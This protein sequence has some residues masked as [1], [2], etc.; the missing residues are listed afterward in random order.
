MNLNTIEKFCD[1]ADEIHLIVEDARQ[2]LLSCSNDLSQIPHSDHVA[3]EIL[4]SYSMMLKSIEIILDTTKDNV[5][6][7]ILID[8]KA[9]SDQINLFLTKYKETELGRHDLFGTL[10]CRRLHFTPPFRTNVELKEGINEY[11]NYC[12]EKENELTNYIPDINRIKDQFTFSVETPDNYVIF[13]ETK[14][15]KACLLIYDWK[16]SINSTSEIKTTEKY[17]NA[18]YKMFKNVQ[19]DGEDF[20]ER[21]PIYICI[22][23][24]KPVDHMYIVTTACR[25]LKDF[26]DS[27]FNTFEKRK[28]YASSCKFLTSTRLDSLLGTQGKLE[29][30]YAESQ[31]LKHTLSDRIPELGD[32]TEV[33]FSHWTSEYKNTTW[34]NNYLSTDIEKIID[35]FPKDKITKPEL[36]NYL[37]GNFIYHIKTMSN[38]HIS[39]KFKGYQDACKLHKIT[40]KSSIESLEKYIKSN[41]PKWEN[42]YVEHYDRIRNNTVKKK[43]EQKTI[44][45][46]T[47]AFNGNA[48]EY[49]KKYPDCFTNE[50]GETKTNFPLPWS[51]STVHFEITENVD[52]NNQISN[53]FREAFSSEHRVIYN[54]SYGEPSGRSSN[55]EA[56]YNLASVCFKLSCD[57][58]NEKKIIIEDVIDIKD[59]SIKIDREKQSSKE[60]NKV[61]EILTRNKNEFSLPPKSKHSPAFYRGLSAMKVKMSRKRKEKEKQDLIDKVKSRREY[62]ISDKGNS[63]MDIGSYTHNKKLIKHDNESALGWCD[64][65]MKNLFALLCFDNRESTK[66]SNVYE[67]YTSNPSKMFRESQMIENEMEN[68]KK[69]NKLAK[70]LSVYSYSDDMMQFSKGLMVADRFMGERDFKIL[71]SSNKSMLVIAFK[72]DGINTGKSGVP[73]MSL[74]IVDQELQSSFQQTYTRELV[75]Y[76]KYK[77]FF[78]NIMRPQR[79]NQVRLLS[80]FK[81]PSKL[82][83]CFAQFV[84]QSVEIMNWLVEIPIKKISLLKIKPSIKE[85]IKD[86]L[87]P[88]IILSTVTKLSRM[89]IFD[90][91]RYAGFLPLSDY[92]NIKEYILEK[93]DP[94]ITNV[95]DFYFVHTIKRLLLS[96]EA[97]SLSSK[98]NPLT[99]DHENDMIGG[100]QDLNIICPITNSTLRRLE[101]LYNNVYLSIYMMP[102]SLQTRVHNLTS[103]LDVPADWELK[104]RTK[105]GF[106]VNEEIYPKPEMF[107][108]SGSFSINGPLNVVS[109]SDYYRDVV[110]NIGLT[111]S[112][113]ESRE[114]FIL[115][116]YKINT[117][118]SSKKCSKADIISDK[119]IFEGLNQFYKTNSHATKNYEKSKIKCQGSSFYIMK[120]IVKAYNENPMAVRDFL[121]TYS[122]NAGIYEFIKQCSSGTNH[123]VFSSNP[124]KFVHLNH[125]LTVETYLKL[126]FSH[127]D[128]I[129]EVNDGTNG[130][131]LSQSNVTVLKSK[132]VSE[133]LYDLIKQYNNIS[134]NDIKNI[135]KMD[136]GNDG[137][138][139]TFIQLL[140]FVMSRTKLNCN[141]TDFL[142]SVFEKMQRTKV[143]REIYLMSMKV[144]M[145]LYFIEHTYKHIAQSDPSE[146]ISI[147][148][149]Y[150]IKA[151]AKLSMDTITTY[152][153][154]LEK[155]CDTKLS[156]LSADQSKWSASDLTYKY[157]LAIIMNPVLTTGEA[158]L[159]IECMLLYV[160]AKKVCIPTDIFMNLRQGQEKFGS[161]CNAI[162]ILTNFLQTNTF[163]VSMNWLQG[164]LNYLSSVYHSCAML[165]Y[166]KSMN[167]STLGNFSTKWMVHS[168]DN[169]TS[170]V[171]DGNSEELLKIYNCDNFSEFLFRTIETHFKSFCIT[172]NPKKSYA[173]VSLVEFISERIVNGAITPL[174]CRHLANCCTESSHNSYY[175]DLMSLTIHVTMLLRKGCPTEVIPYAMSAVQTQA[176]SI[177]SMLPGEINDSFT[178]AKNME[179]PLEPEEIPTCAGGWIS[180]PIDLLAILGPSANDQMIYYNIL[181]KTFKKKKFNDLKTWVSR[182]GCITDRFNMF[183]HNQQKDRLDADEMKLK[184]LLN[185]FKASILSEDVDTIQVGM[186]FQ[187]MISQIIKL[188]SFIGE[189]ALKALE[190][191]K[192]FCK[193]YP[194]LSKTENLSKALHYRYNEEDYELDVE[195]ASGPLEMEQMYDTL[196]K[197]PEILLISPLCD[198]DY[199]LSQIHLYSS[200]SR[201]Y[202]LSTQSTEKLA[203]DRILRSK[204]KTFVD[205]DSEVKLSYKENMEKKFKTLMEEKVTD[206]GILK[207]LSNLILKDVNFEMMINIVESMIPTSAKAKTNY[208][209][210]WYMPVKFPPLIEGSPGLIV[211]SGCYGN[212]YIQNLGLRNLPLDFKSMYLLH[213]IFGNSSTFAD[214]K[215]VIERI[216]SFSTDKFLKSNEL[217]RKALSV[218]YMIQSQNRLLAINTCFQRK[219][220]PFYSVYN[221]GRDMINNTLGLLSTI[222]S[223]KRHVYFYSNVSFEI[224]RNTRTIVENTKDTQ[225]EKLVDT[226]C[227][228]TDKLQSVFDKISLKQCKEIMENLLYLGKPIHERLTESLRDVKSAINMVRTKSHVIMAHRSKLIAIS[229]Y[230]P[231]LY[232]MGYINERELKFI[233]KEFRMTEVMY[234]KTEEMDSFGNYVKGQDYKLG[235]MTPYNYT[236][237]FYIDGQMKIVCYS[238]YD[239]LL[240]NRNIS[241]TH[242]NSVSKV[243][244]KFLRDKQD[245]YRL[246]NN[247]IASIFKGQ[248]CLRLSSSGRVIPYVNG[249][250]MV[251]NQTVKAIG[252]VEWK[253]VSYAEWATIERQVDYT[254]REPQVGECFSII[255]KDVDDSQGIYKMVKDQFRQGLLFK[256]DMDEMSKIADSI[257]DTDT[258]LMLKSFAMDLIDKVMIGLKEINN[259]ND[260]E[261]YIE[262]NCKP[263]YDEMKE[264]LELCFVDDE[265]EESMNVM[266]DG[267]TKYRENLKNIEDMTKIIK[268]AMVNNSSPTRLTKP[269]GSDFN[270]V[271]PRKYIESKGYDVFGVLQLIKACEACYN[272]NSYLNLNS[273][274]K[275]VTDKFIAPGT[276]LKLNL[277]FN[278][279]NEVMNKTYDH[280]TLVLNDIKLSE[281]TKEYLEYKGFV[282]SGDRLKID[283]DDISIDKQIEDN[284]DSY[285]LVTKQMKMLKKKPPHLIPSN[286]IILGELI[287][288]LMLCTDGAE[289]DILHILEQN[290]DIGESEDRFVAIIRNIKFLKVCHFLLNK[291]DTMD[292]PLNE[293]AHS[294]ICFLKICK[295]KVDLTETLNLTNAMRKAIEQKDFSLLKQVH[296]YLNSNYLILKDTCM[297]GRLQLSDVTVFTMRAKESLNKF[298]C[299]FDK[300][301]IGDIED[302]VYDYNSNDETDQESDTD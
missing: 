198:R 292:N 144:K 183:L 149:D 257:E 125:P 174:Y 185:L 40:P 31:L 99:I 10:A 188:P 282:I 294:L 150:K 145:M 236:Q 94:D 27:E 52:Y 290:F 182:N 192:D 190:S 194:N 187:T 220:F 154:L 78:V 165:A 226:A 34:T 44:E 262:Q 205:P 288:F 22:C 175:D 163:S 173:A 124:N 19:I 224:M 69:I 51:P 90:F 46:I 209:Y 247:F 254:V 203:L 66:T 199:L 159:M 39:D 164:N 269:N 301:N 206:P 273:F 284:L 50:L 286:T 71:T 256:E 285:D 32:E 80:L 101:D 12:H 37:Y 112:N 139:H 110:H 240:E 114:G 283:S 76:F 237:L 126:R 274:G 302:I 213:D 16:V 88:S 20:L 30:Y 128:P 55:S 89:G 100:I 83:V 2:K 195:S 147:S 299:K 133:E 77:G 72:G 260:Y 235:Y 161:D 264:M 11:L 97:I 167:K 222:Y 47:E 138:K 79:L 252:N 212:D 291:L 156:F 172:L 219:S 102:K 265:I 140:E 21:H 181:L 157:V 29:N 15:G 86:C 151:L 84:T 85:K 6:Q 108:D 244:S 56:I 117:L 207:L 137:R 179:F 176:L 115:P 93:F 297:L 196:L 227:Y 248:Y 7:D 103:L 214:V 216:D 148:G 141:H 281:S 98:A 113:I 91:M 231:W 253:N 230:C 132:K 184:C 127:F 180:L 18:I 293:V 272:N 35:S 25:V 197:N 232:N 259:V 271:M 41:E 241:D 249:G 68:C 24:L 57:T 36:V 295:I 120:G 62:D 3:S 289:Y 191:Y 223:R 118:T 233:E 276:A 8:Q 258:R 95:V 14:N 298:I 267:I 245:L 121:F 48:I 189:N 200:V 119:E 134:E 234:I 170:L 268:F 123:S 300:S 5:V 210:R 177:Y 221:L 279:D 169:T 131:R 59:G 135:E 193:I 218:N 217:Q 143:D 251:S 225:L 60:W 1:C 130:N 4:Q 238:P 116:S 152:N 171:F 275:L 9:V 250:E 96:M 111:R 201:R 186:K 263:M 122:E 65:I 142:V 160:K 73:Y 211:L 277:D 63:Q 43:S 109:L 54:N 208:N 129:Q 158:N 67:H 287:K 166:H 155:G 92:S 215:N 266:F 162:N 255:H 204:A 146:S 49:E 168:D 280:K 228:I 178:I 33:F 23:V 58:T 61:G 104:F 270:N 13:K 74:H 17:Y 53:I 107:N 106:S 75:C 64:T 105:M 45:S 38:L 153:S 229:K 70:L 26:H 42:L 28:I 87:F 136:K 296:I 243:L 239:F 278:L 242:V 81:T 246:S 261:I 202:Q 82:P